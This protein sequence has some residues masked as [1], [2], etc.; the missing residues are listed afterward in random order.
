MALAGSQ[1]AIDGHRERIDD[2][3]SLWGDRIRP[4]LRNSVNRD[5]AGCVEKEHQAV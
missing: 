2:P 3:A 4:V 5:T 1:Q